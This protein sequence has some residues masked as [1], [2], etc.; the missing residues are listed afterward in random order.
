[1]LLAVETLTFYSE[2][3]YDAVN[4]G[5]GEAKAGPANVFE[6]LAGPGLFI[7]ANLELTDGSHPLPRY[8]VFQRGARRVL[9]TGVLSQG[10]FADFPGGAASEFRIGDPR[11]SLNEVLEETADTYDIA[12][13]L[14]HMFEPEARALA[15]KL[16]GYDVLIGGWRVAGKGRFVE[17][18]SNP[19]WLFNGDNGRCFSLIDI[20][21]NVVTGVEQELDGG[22]KEH[23]ETSAKVAKI[24]EALP[25]PP[26]R[27][28]GSPPPS[29]FEPDKLPRRLTWLGSRSCLPCH[30]A[31]SASHVLDAH[32]SAMV[33]L[34]IRGQSLNADCLPCHSTA[35]GR[36]NGFVSRLETPRLAEVGCEACHGPGSAHLLRQTGRAGDFQGGKTADEL[37]KNPAWIARKPDETRCVKCHDEKNDPDFD[38][39]RD[40]RKVDHNR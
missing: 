1:M 20:A 33:T 32:S 13:A 10:A 22:F 2:T 12:I 27:L 36:P 9:V 6:R 24:R 29:A 19:L 14:V 38:Y 34:V 16:D 15:K 7:S 4:F 18:S 3:G 21:G 26:D 28:E 35:W 8:K 31:Q 5:W 40:L 37:L 39:N 30:G 25:S 17:A 11:S 23:S